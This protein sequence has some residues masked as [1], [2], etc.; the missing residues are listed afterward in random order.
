MKLWRRKIAEEKPYTGPRFGYI[1]LEGRR[2]YLGG[3]MHGNALVGPSNVPI[4][5]TRHLLSTEDPYVLLE[6]KNT[7][8]PARVLKNK[9]LLTAEPVEAELANILRDKQMRASLKATFGFDP[10]NYLRAVTFAAAVV[11]PFFWFSKRFRRARGDIFRGI[12]PQEVGETSRTIRMSMHNVFNRGSTVQKHEK[13]WH[14]ALDFRS[15]LMADAVLHRHASL[16]QG[17][18]IALFSGKFHSPQ[19]AAFLLDKRLFND[20]KEALPAPLAEIHRRVSEARK[21]EIK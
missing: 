6:G 15:F 17:R 12:L 19:V 21:S 1:K 4:A 16:P 9:Q 11:S 20:Y 14:L 8:V 13:F 2:V 7:R 18:S 5:A 3:F 10:R